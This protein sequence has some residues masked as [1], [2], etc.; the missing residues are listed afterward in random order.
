M[1]TL[2]RLRTAAVVV[3]LIAGSLTFAM[4][5]QLGQAGAAGGGNVVIQT[6]DSCKQ[7]LGGADYVMTGG[8][9]NLTVSTPAGR[10]SLGSSNCPLEQGDCTSTSIGCVTF[11]N[12]PDGTYQIW[13]TKT[14][15][16]NNSNPEGYAPCEGGS[17]CQ[18]QWADVTVSG[19]SVSATVTNVYPDGKVTTFNFSGTSG[20]PIVFHDFGLASPGSAGNA[21]CDGDSDADDHSTGTPS[22]D[23]AYPE[24]R[25][26]SACQPFPWSC[27]M[28]PDGNGTGV[29]STGGGTPPPPTGS[30]LA[31]S[32]PASAGAFAPVPVTVT[33]LSGAV[34]ATGF[35]GTVTL[36]SSSDPLVEVPA[37]Y[38]FTAAD[39]G[40]HTFSVVFRHPGSQ[41]LKVAAKK[42]GLSTAT[43]TITVGNDDASWVEDLY[44]DILGRTGADGEVG[45]WVSQLAHGEPRQAVAS[46]FSTSPE[47][48]GRMVD[49]AYQTLIGHAADPGG[50]A[51]W[52]SQLEGGA[53]I[54]TLLSGLASTPVY[55]AGHGRGTDS[56]FVTALY[57][58]LLG[59]APSSAE[60]TSWLA[61]GPI[62]D[63]AGMARMIAFSHEHHL[64]VSSSWYTSYL[65]RAADAAGAQYWAG[66]LDHGTLDQ[67]GVA[68]FT[69]CAEYYGKVKY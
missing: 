16:P 49:A 60:V 56:G 59:R 30:R 66:Q 61:G 44:H 28:G 3:A 4:V 23:C 9:Q 22:G 41:T 14:P 13:S 54:E 29:P 8:G 35:L 10:G 27:T 65:G 19:G 25:E 31:I 63:R 21:Q 52:I 53:N 11:A 47:V 64:M 67:V 57:H 62:A 55:Y 12:V 1:R 50:R 39:A 45:Y 42:S 7:T 2:P 6:M 58:D 15:P 32:M 37:S 24:S 40:A 36:S 5:G 69:S 33:A 48:D 68:A 38:T 26:S 43:A 46:F 20:N 17:A 18:K 34:P 51:Y